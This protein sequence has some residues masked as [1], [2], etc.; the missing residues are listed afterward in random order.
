MKNGLASKSELEQTIETPR[1]LTR[2]ES[3]ALAAAMQQ[4]RLCQAQLHE[5][6]DE[7]G[8]DRSKQYNLQADGTLSLVG[9][10]GI[11]SK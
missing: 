9:I 6:Y 7:L 3:L 2:V 10:P 8:L 11:G 1:K 5:V 4:L